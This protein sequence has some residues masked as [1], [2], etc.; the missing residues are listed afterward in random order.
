MPL[1]VNKKVKVAIYC[2]AASVILSFTLFSIGEGGVNRF[3][4][5][6]V[7]AQKQEE[8]H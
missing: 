3:V 6:L 8:F 1:I 4:G 2:L 5:L 7:A